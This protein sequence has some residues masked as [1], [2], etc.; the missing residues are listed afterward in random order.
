MC[1]YTCIHRH[2]HHT[3]RQI[4][5]LLSPESSYSSQFECTYNTWF[6][7]KIVASVFTCEYWT[8]RFYQSSNVNIETIYPALSV[9]TCE[10]WNYLADVIELCFGC[11]FDW[12]NCCKFR[13]K[14]IP[15]A[16]FRW[17]L[18]HLSIAFLLQFLSTKHIILH[19]CVC[20]YISIYLSIYLY[21]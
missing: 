20:V 17:H 2:W 8:I 18:H 1:I 11:L 3:C 16:S 6:G 15:L 12:V 5:T 19:L 13:E 14:N 7:S 4:G 10:Y 21:R 9:F